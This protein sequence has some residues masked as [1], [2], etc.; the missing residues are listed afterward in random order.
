MGLQHS[1]R[2]WKA[3]P[4]S[5]A[6]QWPE[7]KGSPVACAGVLGLRAVWSATSGAWASIHNALKWTWVG[8]GGLWC[9]TGRNSS[10]SH[11]MAHA[12]LGPT[13][14][15]P[16]GIGAWGSGAERQRGAGLSP[17]CRGE[18]GVPLD[19]LSPRVTSATPGTFSGYPPPHTEGL[20]QAFRPGVDLM[21]RCSSLERTPVLPQNVPSPLTQKDLKLE[22]V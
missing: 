14:S 17:R 8:E 3:G 15:G 16:W 18:G 5:S 22:E 10:L 20:G 13:G 7:E 1:K 6:E 12:F 2:Q 19:C 4:G 9:D 21:G 11:T